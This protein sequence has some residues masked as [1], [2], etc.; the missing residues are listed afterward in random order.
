MVLNRKET[1]QSC[2]F[3]ALVDE[4]LCE[5]AMIALVVSSSLA[6][7]DFGRIAFAAKQFLALYGAGPTVFLFDFFSNTE[8]SA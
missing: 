5:A 3:S 4:M 1:R 8:R 2:L 6:P 7:D